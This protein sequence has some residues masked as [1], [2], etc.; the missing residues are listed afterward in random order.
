MH[1]YRKRAGTPLAG[2]ERSVGER[3]GNAKLT[4]SDVREIR[5]LYRE[6]ATLRQLAD[7]FGVSN[8]SVFNAVSGRTWRHLD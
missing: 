7:K 5:S 8:V 3:H 2:G 6:G 1:Y 4:A